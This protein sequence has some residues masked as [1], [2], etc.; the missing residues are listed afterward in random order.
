MNAS[1]QYCT[2]S[3]APNPMG[4]CQQGDNI[5]KVVLGD[6]DLTTYGCSA[7]GYQAF[8]NST[9]L[10]AGNTYIAT[11]S[12]GNSANENIRI[13]IDWNND[14]DFD[15]VDEVYGGGPST[16]FP[17]EDVF[18]S[19]TVPAN[20]SLGSKRIRVV[21]RYA[22]IPTSC[23]NG[24]SG[25]YGETEDYN[26][27]VVPPP[28]G[29]ALDFESGDYVVVDNTTIAP[30][31]TGSS[32]ITVESWVYSTA[33]PSSNVSIVESPGQFVLGQNAA[34]NFFF[35][36][37]DNTLIFTV[38]GGTIVPN[39]WQHVVGIYGNGEFKLYVD[40]VLENTNPISGI[41]VGATAGP[42]QIGGTFTGKVDELRLWNVE[43]SFCDLFT[44]KNI[45]IPTSEPGLLANYH[46]NQG[47]GEAVNFTVDT[48]I[49]ASG[50]NNTG[51]LQDFALNGNTGNW[52]T[53]SSVTSGDTVITVPQ[54]VLTT[55]FPPS[56]VYCLGDELLFSAEGSNYDTLYW[57]NGIL[58][59]VSFTPTDSTY[60]T[61]V[62]LN[63]TSTCK[64]QVSIYVS[65]SPA[66][67]VSSNGDGVL[68]SN[69]GVSYQWINCATNTAIAGETNQTF[70]PTANGNYAVLTTNGDGCVDTSNCFS[71]TNVGISEQD[72]MYFSM[73]PNPSKDIVTFTFTTENATITLVDMKGNLVKSVVLH[74]NESIDIRELEQ[75]IYF[76]HCNN[77]TQRLIKL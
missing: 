32:E 44:Y 19:V 67:E 30:A 70:T 43:R 71:I 48:L 63:Q 3:Y 6:I 4:G 40:G 13:Y 10:I 62:L 35:S 8:S 74:S 7:G 61:V 76:V 73:V 21:I 31:L 17:Y 11:V 26:A 47:L 45:E 68:T 52:V 15:D 28:A 20:A 55:V 36:V 75:G 12:T 51:I 2:P 34:S 16:S 49:D 29:E 38:S 14:F 66:A 60:Y 41:T 18:I 1:A 65:S 57:N 37:Q 58:D 56:I 27:V 5:Y 33:T 59:S 64:A 39:Q 53:N 22:G 9:D 25:L 50:N 42:L 54:P 72:E 69:P 23:E 24:A 46:F 77:Q